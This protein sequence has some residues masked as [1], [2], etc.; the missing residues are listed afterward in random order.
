[1]PMGLDDQ[2]TKLHV[3]PG[4]EGGAPFGG[5]GKQISS[6]GK[7]SGASLNGKVDHSI[8]VIECRNTV[9]LPSIPELVFPIRQSF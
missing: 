1:M 4:M 8:K 7:I 9:I 3:W 6:L 2:L 5:T